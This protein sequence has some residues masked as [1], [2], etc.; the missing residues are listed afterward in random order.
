MHAGC[1]SYPSTGPRKELD[2]VLYGEGIEITRL[3]NSESEVLGPSAARVRF[4]SRRACATSGLENAMQTETQTDGHWRTETDAQGVRWLTLDK[5]GSGTNTLDQEVLTELDG[6]LENA[7]SDP[8]AGLAIQSGKR[9]GF[10]AGA[11]IAEF[12]VLETAEQGARA[13]ARGQAVLAKLAALPCP[14]VALIDGYAPRR[15][16]RARA[17]VRL[18]H[19]SRELR[20]DHRSPRGSAWHPPGPSVG[21][22]A[23]CICSARRSPWTSC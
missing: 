22:S 3:S 9:T 17:R 23:R 1:P 11:D 12:S 18:P 15:R 20:A 2:F 6:L 8:P 13:A 16:P 21:R 5:T 7:A 19:R 10:I 14:T 4:R